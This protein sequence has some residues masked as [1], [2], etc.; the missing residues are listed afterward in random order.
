M[1]QLPMKIKL[2]TTENNSYAHYFYF[3][4]FYFIYF[5]FFFFFF[6]LP[7]QT[8]FLLC[9]CRFDE[10]NFTRRCFHDVRFD[11]VSS[12]IADFNTRIQL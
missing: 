4:L 7:H 6:S 12:H 3:I 2:K 5:F 1:D 8:S 9:K 10:V 11:R